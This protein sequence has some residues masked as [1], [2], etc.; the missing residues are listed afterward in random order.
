M[1]V[2]IIPSM[3]LIGRNAGLSVTVLPT[4]TSLRCSA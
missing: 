1:F 3:T 4:T 2:R